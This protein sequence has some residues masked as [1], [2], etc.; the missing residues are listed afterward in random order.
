V[1]GVFALA[2]ASIAAADAPTPNTT[3]KLI[4][5]LIQNGA[6]TRDQAD[7]LL[8]QAGE[9]AAA[10]ARGA[11]S[12]P[13]GAEV[14]PG[15]VRVPYIPETVRDKIK[16]DLRKEVIEQAQAEGWA[17]P[18]QVP[19][20]V[21]RIKLSGDIRLRAEWNILDDSNGIVV[22]FQEI[23]EGDGL[24][25]EDL[26]APLPTRNTTDDRTRYRLR[27]RLGVGAVIDDWVSTEF[28]FATGNDNSPVS[29]NQTFGQNGNSPKYELWIDRAFLK[30]TPLEDVALTVGRVPN[31]FWTTDLHF[32]EDLNFDGAALQLE[33]EVVQDVSLFANAGAFTIF[34]TSFNFPSTQ[35]E[36]KVESND[37]FLYAIQGGVDWKINEDYATKFG[38]GYFHYDNV[39]GKTSSL[40]DANTLLNDRACDTD[41]TRPQFLQ[42]GNT[43]F[44]IR[45]FGAD[46]FNNPDVD[47]EQFFGLASKF[48]ILDINGR[49]DIATFDPIHVAFQGNFVQNLLFNRTRVRRRLLVNNI[50]DDLVGGELG[51]MLRVSV[52][53]TQIDERWD[54]N[55]SFGYKYLETDAVLDAFTD[56]DFH[57]GGTNAE[58]FILA[59]NLG[60]AKN[61]F[62]GLR[63]LSADEV[64]GPEFAVDTIQLDLNARF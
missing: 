11:P 35:I 60:I 15:T 6:L 34:N 62:L 40:C 61:T 4:E 2:S 57:L 54:W 21:Q 13:S 25:I 16:E 9:E 30:F 37:K 18:N 26:T 64:S 1:A 8:R 17:E 3:Q 63:Y 24:N 12:Q 52:G 51:Y 14:P 42:G 33:H 29:T 56:S 32:D 7:A 23:N 44:G 20:W 45:N 10:A 38:V 5:I 50:T 48:G 36:N 39:E 53:H 55:A 47:P 41:E 58:G 22:D 28:R 31:P 27:A 49:F 59:G 46:V 43:L 19:E